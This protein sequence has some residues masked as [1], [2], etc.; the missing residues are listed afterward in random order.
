VRFRVS[1]L[2]INNDMSSNFAL[3]EVQVALSPLERFEEYLQ[4]RAKRVTRQRRMI[5]E[6]IFSRH[7]HFDAD[8]LLADLQRTLGQ[9][10]VS[11]P[12][13]YRT[14]TELVDAGLLRKMTLAGRAVYE[15]DYGYPQHD[16]VYCQQCEKLV[17]FHSEAVREIAE[18]AA[19]E[20]GFR[21]VG[22]RFMVMGICPE[23]SRRRRAVHRLDLV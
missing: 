19:R 3:E 12:T 20:H 17:E 14:L 18:A 2:C 1:L 23:C 22:H 5:V 21:F 6:Q 4:S 8:H 9:R 11:R 13:V 10:R 15:H 7:D 16:H